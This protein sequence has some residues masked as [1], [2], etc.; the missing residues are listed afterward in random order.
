MNGSEMRNPLSDDVKVVVETEGTMVMLN[1]VDDYQNG[2]SYTLDINDT[3]GMLSVSDRLFMTREELKVLMLYFQRFIDN[4]PLH[5]R[6][7][8]NAN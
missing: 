5:S 1:F 3:G 4:E 7:N 2:M 6:V 8:P